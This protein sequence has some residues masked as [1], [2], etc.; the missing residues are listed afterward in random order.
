MLR[1]GLLGAARITP[2]ALIHPARQV[3][4]RGSRRCGCARSGTA[5][6][7]ADRHGIPVVHSTLRRRSRRSV[8][9]TLSTTRCPTACTTNGRYAPCWRASTCS[10]RNRLR[11]THPKPEDM[12]Q[13]AE[14]NGQNPHGSIPLPLPSADAMH[15][16]NRR[17]AAPSGRSAT[18]TSTFCTTLRRTKRHPPAATTWPAAR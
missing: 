18:S 15:A 14:H 11:P 5:A 8:L 17:T 2:A 16:R 13:V 1:I 10:A 9:W 7:F 4:R 12:A 3:R 6:H